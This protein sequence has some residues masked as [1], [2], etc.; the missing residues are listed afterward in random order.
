MPSCGELAGPTSSRRTAADTLEP[1]PKRA[2]R[3]VQAITVEPVT[4]SNQDPLDSDYNSS[5]SSSLRQYTHVDADQ[6]TPPSPSTKSTKRNNPSSPALCSSKRSSPSPSSA[7]PHRHHTVPLH[8]S[9]HDGIKIATTTE[10][11][12]TKTIDLTEE[13]SK[14]SVCEKESDST[15]PEEPKYFQPNWFADS[16]SEQESESI[17]PEEPEYFQP[18]WFADSDSESIGVNMPPKKDASTPDEA[19]CALKD[20]NIYFNDGGGLR[21]GEHL[22]KWAHGKVLV[23]ERGS[24]TAAQKGPKIQHVAETMSKM[25]EA[26]F[27]MVMLQV[28]L[29]ESRMVLKKDPSRP[30]DKK[31]T[32]DDFEPDPRAYTADCLGRKAE[33][34]FEKNAVPQIKPSSENNF[35]AIF[36]AFPNLKD[37]KADVTWAISEDL[38]AGY[39]GL[40]M[41][42]ENCG[43]SRL[44]KQLYFPFFSGDFKTNNRPIAEAENECARMGSA[45]VWH[46]HQWNEVA[47]GRP[48]PEL[49]ED[50]AEVTEYDVATPDFASVCFTGAIAP[51]AAMLFVNWKEDWSNGTMY[52]HTHRLVSHNLAPSFDSSAD[53]FQKQLSNIIDWGVGEWAPG[54]YDQARKIARRVSPG[55]PDIAIP[56][57]HRREYK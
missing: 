3:S 37:P 25:G 33:A 48:I 43:I 19:R 23:Q 49:S 51:N 30:P 40:R 9:E 47:E 36:K 11:Q 56:E 52:F 13:H 18:D 34:Q 57:V 6:P 54:I 29:N 45:M 7:N 20:Q 53:E 17:E 35:A 42:F 22:V 4:K 10:D 8:T 38:L 1:D 44:T 27:Q 55:K 2:R 50:M 41:I 16:E 46:R 26:E 15:A 21:R 28:L 14:D 5:H 32:I 31:L 39:R 12:K 24:P